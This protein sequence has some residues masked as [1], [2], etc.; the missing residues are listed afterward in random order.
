MALACQHAK[1]WSLSPQVWAAN[2]LETP[3]TCTGCLRGR[4]GWIRQSL[5]FLASPIHPVDGDKIWLILITWTPILSSIKSFMFFKKDW[6]EHSPISLRHPIILPFYK[7]HIHK[8]QNKLRWCEY[9]SSGVKVQIENLWNA[10]TICHSQ[11]SDDKFKLINERLPK[12]VEVI[13]VLL[14]I[15]SQ[16]SESQEDKNDILRLVLQDKSGRIT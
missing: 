12:L 4:K 16:C 1:I 9:K 2:G 15:C 7:I 10:I 6:S 8:N 14:N 13:L 11:H 3:K 5:R